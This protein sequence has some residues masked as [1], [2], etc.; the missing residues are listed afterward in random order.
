MAEFV[1]V[2]VI[3]EAD[4]FSGQFRLELVGHLHELVQLL[5]RGQVAA[6]DDDVLVADGLVIGDGLLEV[7]GDLLPA[8]VGA[9]DLQAVLVEHGLDLLGAVAE[10]AG[11]LHEFVAHLADLTKRA[12]QVVLGDVANAVKLKSVFHRSDFL[13]NDVLKAFPRTFCPI[14]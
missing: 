13:S 9:G 8:G 11:E 14:S 3:A 10:E 2:V 7:L 1:R 6:G 12:V 4:A 5:L